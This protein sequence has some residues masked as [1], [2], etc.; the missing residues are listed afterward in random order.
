MQTYQSLNAYIKNPSAGLVNLRDEE[1]KYEILKPNFY[2]L[3]T[4]LDLRNINY[5]EQRDEETGEYTYTKGVDTK[6]LLQTIG[7]RDRKFE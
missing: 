6:Q 3:F 5:N 4:F 1:S 7:A 2:I